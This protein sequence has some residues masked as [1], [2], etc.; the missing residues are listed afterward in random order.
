MENFFDLCFD[1][2]TNIGAM[3]ENLYNWLFQEIAIG[4]F[5]FRPFYLIVGGIFTT[6]LISRL[7]G[8]VIGWIT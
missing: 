5:I 7:I 6:M 1:F 8:K 2:F 4:S 3:M